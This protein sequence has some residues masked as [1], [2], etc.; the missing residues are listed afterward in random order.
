MIRGASELNRST[1]P[2]KRSGHAPRTLRPSHQLV[3]GCHHHDVQQGTRETAVRLSVLTSFS[4]ASDGQ[5]SCVRK[6]C[7]LK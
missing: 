7:M 6:R 1:V 3:A 5:L 4:V 2:W